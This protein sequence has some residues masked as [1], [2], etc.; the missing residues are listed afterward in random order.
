MH[1]LAIVA[2]FVAQPAECGHEYLVTCEAF[3]PK[4][5]RCPVVMDMRITPAAAQPDA[6]NPAGLAV[7]VAREHLAGLPAAVAVQLE[8]AA[9]PD[10]GAR[11]GVVDFTARPPDS[12]VVPADVPRADVGVG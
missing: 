9:D 10:P 12:A 5:E 11:A 7:R 4:G 8:D 3:D 6:G 2:Q 1:T